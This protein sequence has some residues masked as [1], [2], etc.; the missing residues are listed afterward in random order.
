MWYDLDMATA[1]RHHTRAL[2]LDPANPEI[3]AA[4]ADLLDNLDRAGEAVPVW[5]YL[6]ARDPA[7]PS[8]HG[9]MSTSLRYLG[10]LDE[11]LAADRMALSLAPGA[12]GG[13]FG[14]GQTL[15]E[16]GELE[17]ALAEMEAEVYEP[18]RLIGLSVVNHALGRSAES[19]A[20]LSHLIDT[21]AEGWA[22][23]IAYVFADRAEA[24]SAFAWLEIA[25]EYRDAG[26]SEIAV[27]RSFRPVY[28]DSRWLPFLRSIGMSPEQLAAIE[29]EVRLPQ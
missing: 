21:Y 17:G 1:A 10:R 11:A 23:N 15:M 29:F 26:L 14:V 13:H 19:D 5:Q 27:N 24:D 7:N 20:A 3:L 25:V 8:P 18:Y 28:D 12:L 4:A 16:S 2:E 6:I 9:N 22:Y